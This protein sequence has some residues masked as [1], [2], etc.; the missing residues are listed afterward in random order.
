[1]SVSAR[2]TGGAQP[3]QLDDNEQAHHRRLI[4]RSGEQVLYAGAHVSSNVRPMCTT[5]QLKTGEPVVHF[6]NYRT[7]GRNA[8][9]IT[10]EGATFTMGELVIVVN[11]LRGLFPEMPELLTA[12]QIGMRDDG[13]RV[14]RKQ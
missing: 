11:R 5:G 14:S 12:A 4:I 6:R 1:M 9:I 3:A 13:L 7:E 2:D 10:D 8:W